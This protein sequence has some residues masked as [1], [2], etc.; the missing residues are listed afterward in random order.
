MDSTINGGWI[1]LNSIKDTVINEKN[2]K[3]QQFKT[4]ITNSIDDIINI[5]N[6]EKAINDSSYRKELVDKLKKITNYIDIIGDNITINI[7]TKFLINKTDIRDENKLEKI[8]FEL[9]EYLYKLK[10]L[11]GNNNLN[12]E[13][14][15]I[16]INNIYY[17]LNNK[18]YEGKYIQN[19]KSYLELKKILE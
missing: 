6:L 13:K 5:D 17:I 14:I 18:M 12:E 19:K 7:I 9:I 15:Q 2:K 10:N 4:Y 3:E 16:I 1:D 11:F 8:S